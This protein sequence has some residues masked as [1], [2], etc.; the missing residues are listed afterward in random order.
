MHIGI[1]H[2]ACGSHVDVKHV[3]SHLAMSVHETTARQALTTMADTSLEN[4]RAEVGQGQK[5]YQ[6]LYQYVLDNIQEFLHVWEGGTGL[7]NRLICGTAC[8]AIGLD[9]CEENAFNF[10]NHFMCILKNEHTELT[11]QNISN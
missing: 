11:V 10:V 9:D 2:I 6:V 8:M 7:E 4:L 1:W 3:A 5:H